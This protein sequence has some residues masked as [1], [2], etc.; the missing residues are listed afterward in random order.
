MFL[1]GPKIIVLTDLIKNSIRSFLIS[2]A[3]LIVISKNFEFSFK[4]DGEYAKQ[5]ENFLNS[6]YNSLINIL[7]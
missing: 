4:I 3:S 5:F 6:L 7:I 1:F 2:K